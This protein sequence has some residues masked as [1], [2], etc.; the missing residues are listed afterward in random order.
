M[1]AEAGARV[2]CA[3]IDEPGAV[4]TAEAIGGYGM[5]A[6][7]SSLDENLAMVAAAEDAL[8]GIDHIFLNAGVATGCGVGDDFD[9]ELYRRAMGANLDGVIF[10]THAVLPALRRAGG[11][12]IVATASLA[13]LTSVPFDPIYAANK[14]GVVGPGPLARR[15]PRR[16]RDPR[17]RGLP[18]LRREQ[19]H[20]ADPRGAARRGLHDHPRRDGRLDRPAADVRRGVRAVLVR[21]AGPHAGGLRLPPPAR[22]ALSGAPEFATW[23]VA[24]SGQLAGGTVRLA[25]LAPRPPADAGAASSSASPAARRAPAPRSRAARLRR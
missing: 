15:R 16:R 17:Q 1:A 18:R 5:R 23:A 4:A 13:G 19:D 3:D 11:G 22:P 7:V 9:L 8:G 6:D 21:P 20:R 14:H 2:F 25:G 24:K 12:S 10:G